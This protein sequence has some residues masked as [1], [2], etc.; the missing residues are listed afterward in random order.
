MNTTASL[1]LHTLALIT[2]T[3]NAPVFSQVD[4]SN[5]TQGKESYQVPADK[6]QAGQEL[7][8]VIARNFSNWT[9]G[10]GT[11]SLRRI[12]E[13]E[14]DPSITGKEAAVIGLAAQYMTGKIHKDEGVEPRLS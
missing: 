13:L 9:K 8:D 14:K 1:L 5:G 10:E 11:L 3:T 6:D 4:L 2:L 7:K 12:G